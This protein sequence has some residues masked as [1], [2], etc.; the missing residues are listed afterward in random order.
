[1]LN[2]TWEK[3]HKSMYLCMKIK[4]TAIWS[5]TDKKKIVC[6]ALV[7]L[8]IQQNVSLA[9]KYSAEPENF[10][11]YYDVSKKLIEVVNKNHIWIEI[12]NKE[13]T[14]EIIRV[15]NANKSILL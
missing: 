14:N 8:K 2:C 5:S 4:V 10:K 15:V 1:M 13:C 12:L 11:N 7:S 9:S 6:A 3:D